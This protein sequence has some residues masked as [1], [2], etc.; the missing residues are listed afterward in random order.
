MY[1]Q[2]YFKKLL[3]DHPIDFNW[4]TFRGTF[5]EHLGEHFKEPFMKHFKKHF[6]EYL[7]NF[8]KYDFKEGAIREVLQGAF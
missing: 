4:N 6:D 5:K 8:L 2:D 1:F 7:T 3:K